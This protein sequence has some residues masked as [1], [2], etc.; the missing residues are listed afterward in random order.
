MDWLEK[1]ETSMAALYVSQKRHKCQIQSETYFST[2]LSLAT[3]AYQFR[4]SLC[5]AKTMVEITWGG[6]GW[7]GS[8]LSLFM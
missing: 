4:D 3:G 7:V 8:F 6:G 5:F 1:H 2:A